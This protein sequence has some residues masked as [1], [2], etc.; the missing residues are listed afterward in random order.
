[1][2][3]SSGPERLAFASVAPPVHITIPLGAGVARRYFAYEAVG[4]K[5]Y[6]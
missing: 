1:M 5:G 4:F 3:W 2:G 6:R